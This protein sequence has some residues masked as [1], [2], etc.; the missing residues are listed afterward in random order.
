MQLDL[1]T[2]TVKPLRQTFTHVARR[3][4]G[5][6]PASRYQEGIYDLQATIN[7]HY[8]PLWAPEYE[9]FDA[10]RTAIV[11]ADWYKLLDPRQF[12]YGSYTLARARMQEAAEADFALV[13]DRDLAAAIPPAVRELALRLYV[14]LRHLEWG[15]NTNCMFMAAYG[16]GTAFTSP[17]LYHAMDHLG[18]AQYLTRVGLTLGNEA[19]LDEAKAAW[20]EGAEWQGLRKYVE[21]CFVL[22]DWFELF[23]AHAVVL[24]GLLFPLFYGEI[25][26]RLAGMGAGAVVTMLTRFEAEWFGESSRW[27]NAVV[28][29]AAAESEAN[30]A[31]IEGWIAQYLPLARAAVEG[32]A[33]IIFGAETAGVVD[34]LVEQFSARLAKL[35]ITVSAKG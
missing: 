30:K 1:R 21:D 33:G 27:T 26:T 31:R 9:I 29:L 3:I 5:D 15:G 13:E 11:M 23:I 18:M 25:D 10:S 22:S 17:A 24:D 28:K 12:Y 7:F 19:A 2:V 34:Q 4:G 14:P 8:R 32:P 16:F 6:K 35:G 20:I